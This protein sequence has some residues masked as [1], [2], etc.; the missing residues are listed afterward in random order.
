MN[1]LC[2]DLTTSESI[3]VTDVIVNISESDNSASLLI[4]LSDLKFKKMKT[5]KL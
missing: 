2:H 1:S 5:E 4:V 3:P